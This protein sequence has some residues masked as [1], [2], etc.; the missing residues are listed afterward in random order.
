MA[1]DPPASSFDDYLERL[2][3]RVT[4]ETPE[5]VARRLEGPSAPLLVDCREPDEVAAVAL[6]GALHVPRARLEATIDAVAPRRDAPLVIACR[7]GVRSVLVASALGDM[8]YTDVT[9]LAGGVEAWRDAGLPVVEPQARPEACEVAGPASVFASAPAPA[10]APA[11][12]PSPAPAGLG[13]YLRQMR[14]AEVGVEGQRRLGRARVLV[15]GVGG[16]GAPAAL[17]LAAAGVGT[18]VLVDDDVVDLSNLQRQVLY[19]QADLGQPKVLAAASALGRRNPDVRLEPHR[20]R[21]TPANARQ[22][23]AGCDVVVDATDNFDARYL[24]NDTCV[25]LGVPHVH[26]SIARFDGQCAVFGV[27]ADGDREAGPCYRCLFPAPPPPALAPRCVEVGVLG[28]SC[29]VIGSLQATEAL[30][31]LLA[32]GEPLRGRLLT[33]DGLGGRFRELRFPRD[34]ACPV[35][36]DAT[37]GT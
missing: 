30:K 4:E 23:V 7:E 6:P 11:S 33:Y 29:G 20:A 36:G 10:S 32:A 37:A 16:L 5:E 2:R 9:S 17:Y 27:P 28:A 24:I 12:A 14:L 19:R 18:L 25:A 8:G 26:G 21:L 13:R 34:P 31:L 15:V 22:L 35:C 3:A 1:L